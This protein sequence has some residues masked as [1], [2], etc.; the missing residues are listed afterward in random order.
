MLCA[1]DCRSYFGPNIYLN[2]NYDDRNHDSKEV[3]DVWIRAFPLPVLN[4]TIL[5]SLAKSDHT[6]NLQHISIAKLILGEL[7]TA[8]DFNKECRSKNFEGMLACY[9]KVADLFVADFDIFEL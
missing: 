5:D 9:C 7:V 8:Q 3:K 1:V 4:A 6:T 2:M